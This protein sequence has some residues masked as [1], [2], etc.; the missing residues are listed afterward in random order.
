[1]Y[2]GVCIKLSQK[3]QEHLAKNL[4][5]YSFKE[6]I[7]SDNYVPDWDKW[8]TRQT[9][10]FARSDNFLLEGVKWSTTKETNE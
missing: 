10:I 6:W 5:I 3:K 8:E 9:G 1:M 7:L 4:F 2:E